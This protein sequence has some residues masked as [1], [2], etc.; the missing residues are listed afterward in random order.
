MGEIEAKDAH[1]AASF[2]RGKGY[3]VIN[4]DEV[5]PTLVDETLLQIQK[6]KLTD[7]SNFTRQL[8]TMVTAGLQLVDALEILK[9]QSRPA[10]SRVI[11]KIAQEVEGGVSLAD[12]MGKNP[13][14]FSPV[15]VALVRAGEAAGVLDKVMAKLAENLE[16][17]REFTS[18]V[19][20]ALIYPAIVLVGM[21]VVSVVMMVAVVPQMTSMY[22]EFNAELPLPTQILIGL[23]NA[24]VVAWPL[25]LIGA[26][27]AFLGFKKW[28][29]TEIG[30][31][32]W[33]RFL[34]R[35]PIIGPLKKDI[36]LTEFART[37]GL[38]ASAG[39]SILEALRIVA[40]TMDSRIYKAEVNDAALI[41]EKGVS[42]SEAIGKATE[43]P[44]ILSQM[45]AVGEQTGKV[46]E[47]LM[48]LAKFYESESE[49][50][51]K[52]LTSAIEP[53]IMVIMGIGVGFLVF[54]IIMPIYNLT[55]QF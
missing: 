44:Q 48:K 51:V 20:G 41:V 54:A 43:F 30:G 8:S 1:Q 10:M 12:A 26:V 38:L 14:V 33:E 9:N 49:T 23:S 27:A 34:Y 16:S 31:I 19:K 4:V 15:Y 11:T 28:I 13:D 40:D 7:I 35:L 29:A 5:V 6:P 22:K 24:M 36:I 25:M 2:L 37:M 52:A 45:I 50:K 21:V 42:L 53:L 32:M 46:D 18:K 47:T 17:Q 39:I 3:F 55:S